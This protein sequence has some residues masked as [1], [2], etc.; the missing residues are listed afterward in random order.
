M[1][2]G[3]DLLTVKAIE[4]AVSAAVE[5]KR[6]VEL[7]DGGGLVLRCPPSG[8][9]KW[10]YAYRSRSAGGMRRVTLGTFGK[11][12]PALS[13]KAARAARGREEARNAQGGDPRAHRDRERAEQAKADVSFGALCELYVEHV[14][15]RGKLSWKTDEGYLNRPKAKFG[16]RAASSITKRELLDLLEDIARASKSSANR[17]QSTLRTLWG[18]AAERDYVPMTQR[19]VSTPI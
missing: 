8:V 16:K 12:P 17:T 5:T 6:L 18:W 19:T 10:T 3:R 4:A 11:E 2:G 9:A 13:L 15:A 1:A 7:S 14:K